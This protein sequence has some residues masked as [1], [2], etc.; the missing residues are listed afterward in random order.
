M[1]TSIALTL[2]LVPLISAS[3]HSKPHHV[4]RIIANSSLQLLS[5]I[6][7]QPSFADHAS[8]AALREHV[9]A[10][11]GGLVASGTLTLPDWSGCYTEELRIPVRDG[12]TIRA[13][14]YAPAPAADPA[15]APRTKLED[16]S[17][18][19]GGGS[20]GGSNGPLCVCFHGGGWTFGAPE[21]GASIAEPLVKKLGCS[22]LSVGYRLAPERVWPGAV[23][24]AWDAV[25]WVCFPPVLFSFL[26]WLFC[27]VS[28]TW[29]RLC[30]CGRCCAD[31]PSSRLPKTKQCYMPI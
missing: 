28:M 5:H 12:S 29:I 9:A 4:T 1:Y 3:P 30:V 10:Q 18:S 23:E 15:P 27:F 11:I 16:G 6:P 7:P 13:I 14:L 22:V 8:P 20:G 26:L 17:G 2:F 24:D 25:L 19:G 21:F 31:T